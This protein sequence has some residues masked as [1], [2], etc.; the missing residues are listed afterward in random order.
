MKRKFHD[1]QLLSYAELDNVG[2]QLLG[3]TFT[4]C[5]LE[6]IAA[7]NSQQLS[8]RWQ[9]CRGELTPFGYD[10][11]E[12]GLAVRLSAVVEEVSRDGR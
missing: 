7:I 4:R 2:P 5:G 9:D 8:F 12:L 11:Q 6:L 3:Q 1:Q 10:G